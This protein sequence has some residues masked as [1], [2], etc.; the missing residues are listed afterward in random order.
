[1]AMPGFGLIHIGR[2]VCPNLFTTLLTGNSFLTCACQGQ[3]RT[4]RL[5]LS[6]QLPVHSWC[7]LP[8]IIPEVDPQG[9]LEKL[10]P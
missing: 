2:F 3:I 5:F 1:M 10:T 7:S 9:L 6:G 8:V 4:G